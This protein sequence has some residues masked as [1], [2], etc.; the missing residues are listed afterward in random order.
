MVYHLGEKLVVEL[1]VVLDEDLPFKI[2]HDI[3]EALQNK[4][5]SLEFVERAFVHVDFCIDG[6]FDSV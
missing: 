2:T 1:H 3:C 5:N 4:I 6:K